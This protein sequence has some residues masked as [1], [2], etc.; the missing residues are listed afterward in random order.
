MVTQFHV[1]LPV[2]D[3]DKS[4]AFFTRL[5]FKFNPQ[6]TDKNAAGTIVG[7]DSFV[8]LVAEN[9]F[10]LSRR[11]KSAMRR[12]ASRSGCAFPVRACIR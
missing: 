10:R 6:F 5:G 8:M 9:F 3:L 1:S 11:R 4:V 7:D 2:K 12:K